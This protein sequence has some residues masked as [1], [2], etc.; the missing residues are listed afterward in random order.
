MFTYKHVCQWTFLKCSLLLCIGYD[1]VLTLFLRSKL[2]RCGSKIVSGK[3]GG[4]GGG[5]RGLRL[6][7]DTCLIECKKFLFFT[8][9]LVNAYTSQ[10]LQEMFLLWKLVCFYLR[11]IC[12]KKNG[13]NFST[14]LHAGL[15]TYTYIKKS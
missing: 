13:R 9:Y 7:L 8:F 2:S 5:R 14:S 4:G 10:G 1:E 12:V 11:I 15:H 6:K 3:N